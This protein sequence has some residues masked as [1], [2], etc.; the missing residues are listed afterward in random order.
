MIINTDDCQVHLDI[1]GM[2]CYVQA[3]E[4]AQNATAFT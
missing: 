1:I 3:A 2:Y 4:K